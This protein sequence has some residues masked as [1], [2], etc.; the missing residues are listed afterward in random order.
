[1]TTFRLGL[2]FLG[3]ALVTLIAFAAIKLV[4]TMSGATDGARSMN[5]PRTVGR[6]R[7]LH[8]FELSQLYISQNKAA[9]SIALK[10]GDAL[11]PANF[12]NEEL[13]RNGTKWRVRSIDGLEAE[14][15]DV[16]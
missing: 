11:A 13:Q 9:S 1:M 2:A 16:S 10:A 15:Y 6:A 14:T 5:A 7:N 8:L 4:P 3:I 12:L